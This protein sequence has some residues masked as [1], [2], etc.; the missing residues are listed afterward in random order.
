MSWLSDNYEKAALGAGVLIALGLGFM[1]Y[2]N[3][4][5]LEEVFQVAA[6]KH[7]NASGVAG[8][9]KINKIKTSLTA[10]H[11]IV[12][13]EVDGRKVDLFRG[14]ALFAKKGDLANPV[15]LLK[16][17]PVH[18]GIPNS[19]WIKNGID[20]GLS[21]APEQDPDKDGFSNREEF[22]AQT[23][24]KDFSSHPEPITKLTVSGVSFREFRLKPTDF[25]NGESKFKL[26]EVKKRR[27]RE[28]NKMGMQ[29]VKEGNIIPFKKAIYQNRFKFVAIK[30]EQVEKYGVKQEMKLWEIEDLKPNKNKKHYLFD[31]RASLV[32]GEDGRKGILDTTVELTLRA[33]GQEGTP[34]KVELNTPFSLPF[35]AKA[36]VKPYVLKHIDFKNKKI[37]VEYQDAQGTKKT[38]SM[39]FK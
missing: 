5:S 11:V 30:K 13:E 4:S 10:E 31:R 26:L 22:L 20:L 28:I 27:L 33:L 19:W 32:R 1:A 35:D 34:F 2:K 21:D 24:P 38:H 14:V 6:P 18:Q 39:N 7:K 25:G 12:Q 16:S 9:E 15:D 8:L 17:K 29:P 23:N 37:E 3:V 36:K